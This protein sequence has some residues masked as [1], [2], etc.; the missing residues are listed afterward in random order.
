MLIFSFLREGD[1]VRGL[2]IRS[3]LF[4]L[5]LMFVGMGH[6]T[7]ADGPVTTSGGSLFADVPNTHWSL[8]SLKYLLER[9][10]IEGLPNGQFQGDRA[11]TRYEMAAMIKR[12]VNYIENLKLQTTTGT[13]PASSI[14]SEDLDVLRDLIFDVADKLNTL[15]TDVNTLKSA[16]PDIDPNLASRIAAMESQA[17][18]I[19]QLKTQ[20]ALSDKTV[21]E[22][23]TQFTQYQIKDSTVTEEDLA[24]TNQ[25]ILANRIIGLFALGA[26][27]VAIG[28]LTLK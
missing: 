16:R 14:R 20:L 22:L 18:E 8:D 15:N 23:K 19:E 21:R 12:A 24:K 10:V 1:T 25:Q 11:A 13:S 5:A 27:I 3:T 17:E 28:L 4:A 2:I 9:G 7:Q 26:A 6:V